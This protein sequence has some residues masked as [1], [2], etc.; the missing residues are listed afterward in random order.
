MILKISYAPEYGQVTI[1]LIQIF[2]SQFVL[3]SSLKTRT[4]IIKYLGLPS[5]FRFQIDS[6][7]YEEIWENKKLLNI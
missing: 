3:K 6:K 7:G 2:L 5:G 1:N 4:E